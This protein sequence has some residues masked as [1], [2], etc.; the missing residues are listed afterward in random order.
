MPTAV[1]GAPEIPLRATSCPHRAARTSTLVFLCV[2][3]SACSVSLH[4]EAGV[5]RDTLG[6]AIHGGVS[7]ATGFGDGSTARTYQVVTVGAG[8]DADTARDGRV[9]T[10]MAYSA[11]GPGPLMHRF[12][13]T[14]LDPAS[15]RLSSALMLVVSERDMGGRCW[16]GDDADCTDRKLAIGA[17][18]LQLSGAVDDG[19]PGGAADVVFELHY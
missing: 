9:T 10:T 3:T 5:R 11:G 19:E 6:T 12:A 18:G 14:Y 2:T 1:D 4:L 15:V 17:V 8:G 7:F 16:M 13:L